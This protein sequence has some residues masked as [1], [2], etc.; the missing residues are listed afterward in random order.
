MPDILELID[1][2]K[3]GRLIVRADPDDAVTFI[4]SLPDNRRE[5][6][7]ALL[8]PERQAAVRELINYPEGTVGRIMTT[9]FMALAPDATAQGAIDRI[10]ERGELESFFYLYV[11]DETGKLVGVVP[12]RN[13]VIAPRDRKLSDMMIADPSKPMCSWIRKKPPA[14]FRAMNF[15]PCRSSMKRAAW[16]ELSRSMTLSTSLTRKHRRHV[17]DGRVSQRGSRVHADF[18]VGKKTSAMDTLESGDRQP[19]CVGG[20]LF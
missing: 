2:E 13:L 6:I 1:D 5:K 12:I 7:L 8:D 9:D 11:V 17:Q 4:D 19:C 10:R 20:G 15:W 18:P 16:K 14:W 3:I